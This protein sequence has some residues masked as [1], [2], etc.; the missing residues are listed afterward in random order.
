MKAELLNTVYHYL[1][2]FTAQDANEGN[3]PRASRQSG[4]D[5][6]AVGDAL[7]AGDGNGRVGRALQR[8]NRQA[9]GER[10]HELQGAACGVAMAAATPQAANQVTCLRSSS[11]SSRLRACGPR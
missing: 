8:F 3:G 9:L 11:S 4:E 5:K 10:C 6:G 1:G 2:V 7:G